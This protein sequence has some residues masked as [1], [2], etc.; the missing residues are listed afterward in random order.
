MDSVET[1]LEDLTAQL[2]ASAAK[3]AG[4]ERE[5]VR[6]KRADQEALENV[7]LELART[8]EAVLEGDKKVTNKYV[9]LNSS[10]K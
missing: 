9:R 10:K 6:I 5:V 3:V 2:E 7:K 1:L 4:L 8:K